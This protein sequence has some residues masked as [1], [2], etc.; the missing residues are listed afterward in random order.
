MN[1]DIFLIIHDRETGKVESTKLEL[2]MD[3][4]DMSVKMGQIIER[5]R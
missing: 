5:L 2:G 1:P 3:W 4:K